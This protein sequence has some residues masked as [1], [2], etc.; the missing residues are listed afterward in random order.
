MAVYACLKGEGR[1]EGIGHHQNVGKA[2]NALSGP[3]IKDVCRDGGEGHSQMRT[4]GRGI[5]PCGRPQDGTFLEV[6]QHALQ[7]LP[8]DDGY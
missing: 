6:F 7:T 3:S 1:Q 5:G 8:M 4:G 2:I